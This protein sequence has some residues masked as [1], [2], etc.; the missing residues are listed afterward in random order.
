MKKRHPK[1]LFSDALLCT[2]FT[3][4]VSGLLYVL[5]LNISILD[6]FSRAFEDFEFTD[7]YFSKNFYSKQADPE[8]IVVNVGQADR[9]A[10]AQA[11]Q[12]INKF[13]PKAVGI[14]LI[15]KERKADFPDEQLRLALSETENRIHAVYLENGSLKES[16]PFFELD[17]EQGGF[18]NFNLDGNSRVVRE[19]TGVLKE[20]SVTRYAFAGKLAV[21]AGYLNETALKQHYDT[22]IP[23]RYSGGAASFLTLTLEEINEREDLQVLTNAVVLLGYAGTPTGNPYD[24]EDRHFTPLNPNF[25]GRSIPDTYGVYIHAT[26]LQNLKTGVGFYKVPK[27]LSLSIAVLFCFLAILA[28]MRIHKKSDVVFDLSI[29]ILQLLIPVL[30]LYGAL[31]LMDWGIYIA[32]LPAVVLVILGLE[33]IDFYVY[34][35]RVI[36][37]GY[38]WKSY[39]LD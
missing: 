22:E 34:F 39:L 4:I 9:F 38:P 23:I 29:K 1:I 21:K 10:I 15:F 8:I 30:L 16:H 13:K 2:L 3:C 25:T 36:R 32:V 26:I 5:V 11:L 24:I 12:K 14:D 18:I 27:P 33:C 17:Q 6:P 28:G 7:L 31:I 20:D 37:K 19:F 35:Q